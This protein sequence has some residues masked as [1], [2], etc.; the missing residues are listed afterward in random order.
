MLME[1][2]ALGAQ[3]GEKRYFCGFSSQNTLS[4]SRDCIPPRTRCEH[5][6][7]LSPMT[8]EVQHRLA[9]RAPS[10]AAR[11]HAQVAR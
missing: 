5:A 6:A 3:G 9:E 2:K 4:S 8:R 11:I 1:V 10:R 7:L